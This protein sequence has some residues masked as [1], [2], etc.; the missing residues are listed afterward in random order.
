M[1]TGQVDRLGVTDMAT[2][3]TVLESCEIQ[4]VRDSPNRVGIG[5]DLAAYSFPR[6]CSGTERLLVTH[7]NRDAYEWPPATVVLIVPD[8]EREYFADPTSIW[9]R[10]E[11]AQLHDYSQLST[12]L[13]LSSHAAVQGVQEGDEIGSALGIVRVVE[14]PGRTAG[15][16]SYVLDLGGLRIIFTGDLIYG[17]G[18]LL[19]AYS[20]QSA[21]PEANTRGYHG[22]AGRAGQL[23]A[24]LHKIASLK[25]DV[26]IP[27]HG[28]L[29][30]NPQDAIAK[31]VSRIEDLL[32]SHFETDALLWF[33][34]PESH[35]IRSQAA[36]QPIK[37]MPMA[38][39]ADS[40]ADIVPFGTSRLIYS[41]AG[42]AFLVDAG[43]PITL[44]TLRTLRKDGAFGTLEG[45]W[46]THY[47][48]DHTDYVNDVVNEFGCSVYF[49]TSISGILTNPRRFRMPCLPS[50]GIMDGTPVQHGTTMKWH[51][52]LF[53]FEYFP[54]QTLYHGGL[55]A[56]RDD[57]RSYYFVGDSF[58]PTGIDDYCMQNRNLYGY[59]MG[60]TYCL[61]RLSNLPRAT[62]LVNQHVVPMFRF[63]ES[64]LAT[65]KDAVDKRT[66]ILGELCSWPNINYMVDECWV[67]L[68]P[69]T[70]ELSVG[71]KRDICLE[72]CNYS[73]G[74][75][76][77]AIDWSWTAGLVVQ[78]GPA[79]IVVSAG[80]IGIARVSVEA[81]SSGLQAIAC[82]VRLGNGSL[83]GCT[84][85][86][87]RV[88]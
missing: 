58:T 54:G 66:V 18:Q 77:G 10:V 9:L 19:D 81:R 32:S 41:Q 53:N 62:W 74:T 22:Y 56:T 30:C 50:R 37:T 80:G 71:D 36:K 60:Y 72:V 57:G 82:T 13:P 87:L 70:S 44:P 33:W 12:N 48:D 43:D 79:E 2:V 64:Q 21:I 40:P 7:A 88:C 63:S 52:W 20:L 3:S 24:S 45:I 85:A 68:Y 86:L 1:R 6:H 67:S 47:H 83:S 65:M 26:L 11:A 27:A 46:I 78:D 34:G 84:E 31:L 73:N 17:D 51:E 76:A 61:D 38:E 15:A 28:P 14:T 23:I 49:T 4:F 8:G 59:A 42:A 25:P 35:R 55:L 16:V 75:M 39:L 69:R 29:V 5:D